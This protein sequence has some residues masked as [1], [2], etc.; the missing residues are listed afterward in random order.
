MTRQA[1]SEHDRSSDDAEIRPLGAA[2]SSG[3]A[4]INRSRELS[5]FALRWN[6]VIRLHRAGSRG[7]AA[8]RSS[9]DRTSVLCDR[10]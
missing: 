8:M 7:I 4:S 5:C 2:V 10:I 1:E 9:I 3:S 6:L